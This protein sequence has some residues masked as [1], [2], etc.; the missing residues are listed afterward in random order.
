MINLKGDY[1][2]PLGVK[3]NVLVVGPSL[4]QTARDLI[5]AKTIAVDGV[6]GEAVLVGAA[7]F[8]DNTDQDIVDIFMSPWLS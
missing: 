7:G 8:M 5:K 6:P 2:R 1:G 3:P 4:E